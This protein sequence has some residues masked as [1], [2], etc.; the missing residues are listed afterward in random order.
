MEIEIKVPGGVEGHVVRIVKEN[1]NALNFEQSL[2]E[3]E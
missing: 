2:F 3:D 1:A